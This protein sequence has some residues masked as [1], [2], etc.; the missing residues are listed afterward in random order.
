MLSDAVDAFLDSV[1]ERPFDEPLLALLRSQGFTDVHLVHGA[2]EFGKDAIAKRDGMQWALQSKAGDISQGEFRRMSGQLDELRRNPLSHPSFD[3]TLDR[4]CVLVCTGRLTGNAPV[5]AQQYDLYVREHGEPG[6]TVWDRDDLRSMLLN[7]PEAALRGTSSLE[8]LPVFGAVESRDVS[9]DAIEE[10]SRRWTGWDHERLASVGIIELALVADALAR[11]ERVDLAC[12]ATL[13][14]VRA[15]WAA[16]DDEPD[17]RLVADAA[18]GLFEAH[19]SALLQRR[20]DGLTEPH[21]LI[22]TFEPFVDWVTYPVRAIRTAELLA[23]LAMRLRER[24]DQMADEV[25]AVVATLIENHPGCAHP[26]SDRYA[27]SL[28]PMALVLHGRADDSVDKLLREATRWLGERYEASEL[29]LAAED[30]TPDEETERVFG[31]AFEWVAHR[32][33]MESYLATVL[34]DLAALFEL[35]DLYDDIR[36]DVLAVDAVPY[37]VEADDV[38]AQYLRTGQGLRRVMPL[39]YADQWPGSSVVVAR[40]HE[41]DADSFQLG[42]QNRFW[43]Q[44]A[45]QAVLR[46]RHR[47]PALRGWPR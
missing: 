45:I 8:L 30:S 10:F 44:L 18:G 46:D 25:S 11:T 29:G 39:A 41:W 27:T 5:A 1:G 7:D 47:M 40:H 38:P 22:L 16:G 35:A 9:M 3:T 2:G 4:C 42:R 37:I 43:D 31:S 24:G 13:T 17:A 21:G 33:R 32:R 28:I 15:A 19:A 26:F 20:T 36:N 14:M 23:L 34:A 6:L 12:H